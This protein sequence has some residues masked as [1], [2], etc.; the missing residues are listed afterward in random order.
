MFLS[1]S[2]HK[3]KQ[4]EAPG[5]CDLCEKPLWPYVFDINHKDRKEHKEK[6]INY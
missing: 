6:T 3:K 4:L 5:L 2:I 1:Y